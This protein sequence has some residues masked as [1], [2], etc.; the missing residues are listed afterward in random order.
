MKH[1]L[2]RFQTLV[3]L[4]FCILFMG[5]SFIVFPHHIYAEEGGMFTVINTLVFQDTT[6]TTSHAVAPI[7]ES[8]RVVP[9]STETAS[10]ALEVQPL[11]TAAEVTVT[12][13][14][15]SDA[16]TPTPVP[17]TPTV[18][19]TLTPTP[20]VVATV[21]LTVTPT[22]TTPPAVKTAA[23][24]ASPTPTPTVTVTLTPTPE[25]TKAVVGD[26]IWDKLAACESTGNWSIDTGNG[27]FGGLQFSQG[28]WN[29]VG[30][31]GS[32]ASASREE[33]IDKAKKLQ[34]MRGW[35]VWGECAKKLGLN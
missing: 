3:F 23:V 1:F 5:F 7:P 13:E 32:P 27:Y 14:V 10:P 17:P 30:G 12:P 34:A 22:P 24:V 25:P 18:T 9:A 15:L 28:A 16:V 19:V 2:N 6:D 26:E 35:G 33:Q 31:T 8:E 29:S 11:P 4:S 21:T 20:S